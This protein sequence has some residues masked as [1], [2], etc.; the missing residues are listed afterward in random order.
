MTQEMQETSLAAWDGL[1]AKLLGV[2]AKVF[3]AVR[4]AGALGAIRDEIEEATGIVPQ[5]V[6][7]RIAELHQRGFIVD[8]GRTRL[9]RQGNA[10]IVWTLAKFPP[11]A[12]YVKPATCQQRVKELE[13]QVEFLREFSNEL[14]RRSAEAVEQLQRGWVNDAI[15]LLQT[16]KYP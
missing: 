3:K 8:S 13:A 11:A 4:D 1:Q 5:T 9:T 6:S 10:A 14:K 16:G 15:K 2:R 7:G 12:G